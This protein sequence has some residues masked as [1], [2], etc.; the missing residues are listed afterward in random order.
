M[1]EKL[2]AILQGQWLS[3]QIEQAEH[4]TVLF[5]YIH[6]QYYTEF[7]KDVAVSWNE[8]YQVI[9]NEKMM[10]EQRFSTVLWRVAKLSNDKYRIQLA[11][12]SAEYS[13]FLPK[14]FCILIPETWLLTFIVQ[15]EQLFRVEGSEPYWVYKSDTHTL[16]TTA[17][18]GLMQPERIFLD[19]IGAN[20]SQPS[21]LLSLNEILLSRPVPLPWYELIGLVHWKKNVQQKNYG[22]FAAL[23]KFFALPIAAYCVALTIGISWYESRLQGQVTELRTQLNTVAQQQNKLDVKARITN[24]YYQ[25]I[26]RFPAQSNLLHKLSSLLGDIAALQRLDISGSIIVLT[27]SAKSA[28]DVLSVLSQQPDISEVKFDQGVQSVNGREQFVISLVHKPDQGAE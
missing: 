11:A 4:S 21:Q 23:F 15:P 14:G 22:S 25:Q 3:M 6:R 13:A 27:G 2:R 7:T 9:K 20:N 8:L 12:V 10:L 16:H 18:R 24:D 28:T 17:I 19:A 5:N 26:D 1:I